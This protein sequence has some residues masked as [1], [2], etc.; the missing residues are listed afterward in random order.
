VHRRVDPPPRRV[1]AHAPHDL[2]H[3]LALPIDGNAVVQPGRVDAVG[4]LGERR[5]QRH[6]LGL[7]LRKQP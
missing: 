7:Q 5:N 3:H 2:G 1:E 6:E 4:M